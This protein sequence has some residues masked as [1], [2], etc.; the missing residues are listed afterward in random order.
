MSRHSHRRV[1][2]GVDALGSAALVRGRQKRDGARLQA[3]L[4]WGKYDELANPA[5]A[6]R[7]EKAIAGSKNVIIDNCGHM[8]QL[9]C[10]GEFNRI[11]RDFLTNG[12]GTTK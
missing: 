9:E 6:N 10:A 5:G 3:P 12:R 11:V 2:R 1:R 8:P 7:L 4:V